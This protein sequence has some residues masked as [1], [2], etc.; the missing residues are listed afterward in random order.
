MVIPVLGAVPGTDA[1]WPGGGVIAVA[2]DQV[3]GSAFHPG[4]G[5]AGFFGL[6]IFILLEHGAADVFWGGDLV[7][8]GTGC[9][10]RGYFEAGAFATPVALGFTE[11]AEGFHG[12][13]AQS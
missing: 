1:V 12:D 13:L 8:D 9:S 5:D 2:A 7:G 6:G 3:G 4:C 11:L 10:V